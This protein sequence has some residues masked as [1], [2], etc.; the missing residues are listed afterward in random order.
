MESLN[1][2]RE[3][4]SGMTGIVTAVSG[5][6]ASLVVAK[7]ESLKAALHEIWPRVKKPLGPKERSRKRVRVCAA[8]ILAVSIG[9]LVSVLFPQPPPTRPQLLERAWNA[10]NGE[11]WKKVVEITTQL[12]SRF[13]KTAPTAQEKLLTDHAPVPK[14]GRLGVDLTEE[15]VIANHS[16]GLVNDFATALFLRGESYSHL[17]G[18]GARARADLEEV[19][20]YPHAVTWDVQTKEFW[21]TKEGAENSLFQ[22][23]KKDKLTPGG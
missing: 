21:L 23:D 4:F 16:H 1:E 10:Y 7:Q 17:A 13:E 5:L 11:N 6:I 18:Q 22:L 3:F 8:A 14:L 19:M 20:K 9:I 2:L 12:M 15:D